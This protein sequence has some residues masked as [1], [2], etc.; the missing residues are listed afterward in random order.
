MMVT[1]SLL[2]T[3]L[4]A[5]AIVIAAKPVLERKSPM[6]LAVTKRHSSANYNVLERDRRRINSLGRRA[7]GIDTLFLSQGAFYIATVG[8]GQPP[9]TCK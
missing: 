8:I 7:G 9:T 3:S 4:F 6:K 2:A 5:L 1:A